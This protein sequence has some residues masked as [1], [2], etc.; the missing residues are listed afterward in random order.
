MRGRRGQILP[1]PYFQSSLHLN[2]SFHLVSK[3]PQQCLPTVLIRTRNSSVFLIMS[4]RWWAWWAPSMCRIWPRLEHHGSCT[5]LSHIDAERAMVPSRV[6]FSIVFNRLAEKTPIDG[7]I[8]SNVERHSPSCSPL[9][10]PIHATCSRNHR[11]QRCYEYKVCGAMI[12]L[13][14][15]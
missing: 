11:V 2:F 10:R 7:A 14:I 8:Q 12:Y 5:A 4:D 6:E 15:L 3:T 1:S 9:K 13:S